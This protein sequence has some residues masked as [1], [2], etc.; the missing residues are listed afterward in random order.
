MKK[1]LLVIILFIALFIL[2]GIYIKINKNKH[3]KLIVVDIYYNNAWT[4]TYIGKAIFDDGSIY[5]WNLA[6]EEANF[7]T[8]YLNNKD[9]MEDFITNNAQKEEITISKNDLK[10]LKGYIK[11]LSSEEE[12]IALTCS[13]SDIGSGYFIVWKD[14]KT[15]KILSISGDCYGSLDNQYTKKINNITNKYF[16]KN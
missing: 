5:T 11:K 10:S 13:G 7:D 9:K 1:R 3:N 2:F 14:D 15:S 8:E 4:K 12:N 6:G 16:N